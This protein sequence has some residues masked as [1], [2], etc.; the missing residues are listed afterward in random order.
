MSD[1]TNESIKV[2][3]IRGISANKN[4]LYFKW[5]NLLFVIPMFLIA[6]DYPHS[7]TSFWLTF[8]L[9]LAY[10]TTLTVLVSVKRPR[11]IRKLIN[12]TYYLDVFII[13]AFSLFLGGIDS[14]IYIIL[15]FTIAYFGVNKDIAAIVNISIFT[16]AVYSFTIIVAQIDAFEGINFLKLT[17]RDLYILLASYG[18]S[19]VV[20]Q[21]KKYDEMHKREFKLARTDKLTGLANRHCL[22]QKLEEE[23]LYSEYSKMPLNVLMFDL[24]NFKKFNDSY[25][26]VWGDKLLSIFG[27]IIMQSIRK[28][29]IPVRYGGE[30]FMILIRDLDLE[31]AKSIGERIRRQ[32]ENQKLLTGEGKEK[33]KITVSCGIAQFPRHSDDIKKVVDYA[34]QALYYAKEIG[35][36]IV[37]SY[38]EI[39]KL[40]EAVQI[41]IDSY[42]R[43]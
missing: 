5:I 30:E 6:S 43:N 29:D 1:I 11:W 36:N 9:A 7:L 14:D 19:M 35:K 39:G 25:G 41:D 10:N 34:D 20:M 13:C 40:R 2:K 22:E 17:L 3:K 18:V 4:Y 21:V 24:D 16:I 15:I 31:V 32:L 28:T 42:L 37:V 33:V 38:D 8:I 12:L 27:E 23:A 26:H